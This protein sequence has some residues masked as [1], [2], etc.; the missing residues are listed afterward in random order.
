MLHFELKEF[1][2]F[3]RPAYLAMSIN[4]PLLNFS[5]TQSWLQP[6]FPQLKTHKFTFP[7]HQPPRPL[8]F[9]ALVKNYRPFLE[10]IT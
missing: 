3:S 5:L 1:P 8:T 9:T 6:H 7:Y 4:D 10:K 2:R